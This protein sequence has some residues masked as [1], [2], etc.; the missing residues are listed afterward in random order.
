[1]RSSSEVESERFFTFLQDVIV[2]NAEK[3]FIE[4]FVINGL[5]QILDENI[6]G[7][8]DRGGEDNEGSGG[9]AQ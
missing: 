3:I 2:P 5:V 7:S 1:M 8:D 6:A 4:R 9:A